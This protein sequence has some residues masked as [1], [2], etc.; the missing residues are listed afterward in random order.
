MRFIGYAMFGILAG[1]LVG[2]V[3]GFLGVQVLMVVLPPDNCREGA[4]GIAAIMLTFY[5]MLTG[6]GLGLLIGI[7]RAWRSSRR[8]VQAE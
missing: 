5:S 1:G 3:G 6:A 8:D 2:L 4:C 7:W